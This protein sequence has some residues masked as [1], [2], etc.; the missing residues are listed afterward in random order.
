MC[1]PSTLIHTNEEQMTVSTTTTMAP[2]CCQEQSI[3]EET[4]D[5]IKV[6]RRQ[7][8]TIYSCT[9]YMKKIKSGNITNT[10]TSEP[11]S[12]SLSSLKST[13]TSLIDEVCR[14]KMAKWCFHVID[15]AQFNRETVSIA[16]SFLD[17]FLA[18]GSPRALRAIQNRKEYQLASMTTLYMAIKLFEPMEM[19]TTTL[20]SLSRNSYTALDF[21]TMD[22]DIL[23][24]L[25]WRMNGPTPL[26]FIQQFI[27]MLSST[28]T[29]SSR[30]EPFLQSHPAYQKLWNISKYHTELAA[31]EYY[32]ATIQPSTVA[33][34]SISASLKLIPLCE[35]SASERANFLLM[36]A[37]ETGL[38]LKRSPEIFEAKDR[39]VNNLSYDL[40]DMQEQERTDDGN[41]MM[42][43]SS[44]IAT[45]LSMS[46][47][48]DTPVEM[49]NMK[50]SRRYRDVSPTCVSSRR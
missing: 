47:S 23:F 6:M 19:C 4:S 26:S 3:D 22:N 29:S 39:M 9:D 15:Y 28:K 36:I 41:V 49:N 30:I 38:D 1:N 37:S 21:A 32:F 8:Q 43:T 25:Q 7:E 5:R 46:S 12:S 44:S 10:I 11:S 18:S 31:C 48:T 42:T 20:A 13:S 34:A 17:R 50:S 24:A 40:L 14:K 45:T 33:I 16:M 2:H 35:I 27:S